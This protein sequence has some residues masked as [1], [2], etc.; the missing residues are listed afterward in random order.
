MTA[1]SGNC[2]KDTYNA[3]ADGAYVNTAPHLRH[4]SILDLY[5]R[6]VQ[7]AF[8]ATR[9]ENGES[10]SVLDLGAGE[11]TVTRPF[12]ELGASVLAVDIS[13]RQLEQLQV[14]CAGLPGQ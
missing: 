8:V 7:A 14:I 6:L 5:A 3:L 9:R 1:I 13:E 12:L 10:P 11:G 2:N 4:R